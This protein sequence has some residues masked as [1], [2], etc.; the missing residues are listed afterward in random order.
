MS[1]QR[2]P[3][4][5]LRVCDEIEGAGLNSV[6]CT[7]YAATEILALRGLVLDALSLIPDGTVDA[8]IWRAEAKRR[9]VKRGS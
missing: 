9:L 3:R 2:P 6:D 4:E 8:S 1:K 7:V 5:V